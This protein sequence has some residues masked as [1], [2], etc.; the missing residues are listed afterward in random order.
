VIYDSAVDGSV[1]SVESPAFEAGYEYLFCFDRVANSQSTVD[2]KVFRYE[3]YDD[4]SSSY[5]TAQTTGLSSHITQFIYGD[6]TILRP[7]M[8][9]YAHTVNLDILA[10]AST[11]NKSLTKNG[12]ARVKGTPF[13]VGKVRFSFDSTNTTQGKIYMFRRRESI[14]V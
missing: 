6:F 9:L 7:K 12:Y 10:E 3:L 1:G 2:S 4:A 13:T 8:S 11:G 5:V 14:T